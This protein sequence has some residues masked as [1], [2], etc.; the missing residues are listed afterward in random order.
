M[1]PATPN[2]VDTRKGYDLVRGLIDAVA[3]FQAKNEWGQDL[4][5]HL[6]NGRVGGPA[7]EQRQG[8]VSLLRAKGMSLPIDPDNT[9]HRMV[10]TFA[11]ADNLATDAPPKS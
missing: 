1:P 3:D 4:A 11:D 10:K 9:P 5:Y 2:P 7:G 8:V 6:Y